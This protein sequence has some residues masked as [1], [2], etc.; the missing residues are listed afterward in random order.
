MGV[1]LFPGPVIPAGDA[2]SIPI[3]VGAG[4]ILQVGP[5]LGTFGYTTI[6]AAVNDAVRGDT[7]FI[8][9]GSYSENV[10]VSRD[11]ITIVGAQMGG[12]GRPDLEATTGVTLTVTGQGFTCRRVRIVAK[13]AADGV[14]QQGNGFHYE[15]CVF[16]GDSTSGSAALFR[17]V[18][19]ATDS[20]KS[21]SEGTISGCL[22]RGSATKGLVFDSAPIT[23]AGV[24]STDNLIYGCKFN[25]NTG[26]DIE[27]AKTG[28]GAGYSVEFVLIKDC[29][30]TDKNKATYI[31]IT[32]NE[33]GVAGSQSGTVEGCYFA[34][35]TM[36]TTKIKAVGTAFTFVGNY[37]TVGIF[38]GSGLD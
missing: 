5:S 24:G 6:Q 36:T 17:L 10:V 9:P 8:Q 19:S 23:G 37:D 20:H 30:F 13:G 34:T 14:K 27:T 28:A 29:D 22:F 21:A 25:Q 33:D 11:Y 15:D 3:D 16:D 26:P 4:T 12:Y 2:F 18:G 31:D 32:T 35:D 38:D 7:I 1:T